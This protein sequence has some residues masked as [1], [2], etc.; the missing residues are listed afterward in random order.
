MICQNHS[1]TDGITDGYETHCLIN[2]ITDGFSSIMAL[3]EMMHFT[4]NLLTDCLSVIWEYDI[5]KPSSSPFHIPNLSLTHTHTHISHLHHHLWP[6]FEPPPSKLH[7][8]CQTPPLSSKHSLEHFNQ[9]SYLI[10]PFCAFHLF[11]QC[12]YLRIFVNQMAFLFCSL[13]STFGALGAT[14]FLSF[15][16]LACK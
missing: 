9:F 2:F 16:L 4:F 12:C 3:S 10:R 13:G 14:I 15:L 5:C 6:S 11:T 8:H 1:N 7:C